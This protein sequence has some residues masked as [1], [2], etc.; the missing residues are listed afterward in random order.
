M[1]SSDDMIDTNEMNT[2]S[3]IQFQEI[4]EN[5]PLRKRFKHFN[6][7]CDLLEQ[8]ENSASPIAPLWDGN[9]EIKNI[10]TVGKVQDKWHWILWTIEYKR[11]IYTFSYFQ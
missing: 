10:S 4:E 11:R 6:L 3:T 8:E 7:V 1:S 9:K 5:E 2:T